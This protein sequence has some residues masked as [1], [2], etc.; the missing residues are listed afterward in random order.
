MDKHLGLDIPEGD[1]RRKFLEA[2]CDKVEELRYMKRFLPDE[3]D[4]RKT[5]LAEI[6]IKIAELEEEKK[7]AMD[8][9]KALLK[10]PNEQRSELLIDLKNGATHVTELCYKF[11]YS[12]ENMVAYYNADGELVSSRPM[13]PDEKQGTIFQLQR[14]TGTND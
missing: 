12:E 3:M 1:A 10:E 4:L 7:R 2:N 6:S 8:E 13:F 5:A 11:L 14:N 9:F